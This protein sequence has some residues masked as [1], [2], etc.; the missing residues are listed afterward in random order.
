LNHC[1]RGQRKPVP[2]LGAL[3]TSPGENCV[4]KISGRDLFKRKEKKKK[5]VS[6]TS[7]AEFPGGRINY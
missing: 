2:R 3:W 7:Q 6:N 1:P 4:L 5:K